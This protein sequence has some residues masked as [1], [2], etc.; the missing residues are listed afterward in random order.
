[1][2]LPSASEWGYQPQEISPEE[3]VTA[4]SAAVVVALRNYEALPDGPE[5]CRDAGEYFR[6][7][8]E[9]QLT[10]MLVDQLMNGPTGYRAHYSIS[11]DA[12]ERFNRTLVEAV[13]PLVIEA[14]HLYASK[15]DSQFC[16]WSLLGQFSKFW[17]PKQI[18]DPSA[19]DGL[20]KL[21]EKIHQPRWVGYWSTRQEP[22]KGLFAPQTC[23]ILLNG[24]FVRHDGKAYEQKPDRSQQL[25][26]SGWT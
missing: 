22:C 6:A 1:M 3:L 12:G 23:S 25:F 13:A 26:E 11:V 19:H 7:S 4:V 10:T 5:Q 14:E 21:T 16:R 15:F 8:V 17:Y 24:T 18:T 9:I 20:L 2:S